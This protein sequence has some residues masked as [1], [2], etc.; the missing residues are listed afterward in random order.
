MRA[1]TNIIASV[2]GGVL[3]SGIVFSL[4]TIKKEEYPAA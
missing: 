2:I 1:F 4:G 3:D